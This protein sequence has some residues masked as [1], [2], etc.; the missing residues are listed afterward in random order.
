VTLDYSVF[1]GLLGFVLGLLTPHLW[2]RFRNW[3][4]ERMKR[5]SARLARRP[6]GA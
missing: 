1:G 4:F 3:H 6:G 2:R 5:H